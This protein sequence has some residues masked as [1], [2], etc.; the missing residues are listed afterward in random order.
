MG[1]GDE[2]RR[3]HEAVAISGFRVDEVRG[4]GLQDFTRFRRIVLHDGRVKTTAQTT[5]VTYLVGRVEIA[6]DTD[7]GDLLVVLVVIIVVVI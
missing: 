5:R 3:L 2:E 4:N 1:D 6:H 7:V